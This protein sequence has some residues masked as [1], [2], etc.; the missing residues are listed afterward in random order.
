ME[1]RGQ[2]KKALF[3]VHRRVKQMRRERKTLN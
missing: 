2:E 3:V 1:N